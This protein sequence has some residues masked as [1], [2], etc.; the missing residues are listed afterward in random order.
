MVVF[1]SSQASLI[2]G[3]SIIRYN[4][5]MEVAANIHAC[6]LFVSLLEF[7][8]TCHLS[9]PKEGMSASTAFAKS[10]CAQGVLL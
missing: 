9:F 7:E 5:L 1:W 6:L 4:L 10:V 3:T 2:T 8:R